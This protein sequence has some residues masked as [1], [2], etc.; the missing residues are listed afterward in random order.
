MGTVSPSS[1]S[2]G[3]G[4]SFTESSAFASSSLRLAGEKFGISSVESERLI[5]ETSAFASAAGSSVARW[6]FPAVATIC[7]GLKGGISSAILGA[8]SES[9]VVTRVNKRALMISRSPTRI[10]SGSRATCFAAPTSELEM[11]LSPFAL[12][13]A[14]SSPSLPVPARMIA[15][16]A[17][18]AK[19]AWPS[20]AMRREA[21]TSAMPP[22]PASSVPASQRRLTP[23]GVVEA[24]SASSA[25]GGSS[26]RRA[27]GIVDPGAAACV[28][29][30][31]RPLPRVWRLGGLSFIELE[32][33]SPEPS[34][35]LKPIRCPSHWNGR[36][37]RLHTMS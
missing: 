13:S 36:D 18:E 17:L 20:S 16:L 34:K 32:L 1:R 27:G 8:A 37:F 21:P 11:I 6:A 19:F 26:P 2:G 9:A 15:S 4:A 30:D 22:T 31:A 12:W 29:G 5:I 28:K 10:V 25:I 14:N 24:A 33:Y 3:E 23:C 35:H 7:S